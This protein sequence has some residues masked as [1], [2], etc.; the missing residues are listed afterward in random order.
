MYPTIQPSHTVTRIVSVKD[1]GARDAI[2]FTV[3]TIAF[4]AAFAG[5]ILLCAWGASLIF[6]HP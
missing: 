2:L 6:P 5:L 4:M 3:C 1:T